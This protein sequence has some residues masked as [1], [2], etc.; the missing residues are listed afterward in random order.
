ALKLTGGRGASPSRRHAGATAAVAA[1]PDEVGAHDESLWRRADVMEGIAGD[2]GE[3]GTA[4]GGQHD[5]VGGID[6]TRPVHDV[7]I[8]ARQG[9]EV[10]E[11]V[12]AH[13]F[14]ATE[15]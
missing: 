2:E 4:G 8:A 13:V 15:D 12:L 14:E 11:V 5:H 9:V 7:A 1:A 6:D 10:D 3:L